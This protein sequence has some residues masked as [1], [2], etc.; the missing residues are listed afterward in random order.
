MAITCSDITYSGTDLIN[1][2]LETQSC[3]LTVK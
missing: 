3:Y 2:G 1:K